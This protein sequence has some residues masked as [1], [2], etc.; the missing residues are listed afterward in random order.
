M[1]DD[2]GILTDAELDPVAGG[3]SNAL[4]DF[5]KDLTAMGTA[6]NFVHLCEDAVNTVVNVL[7][8]SPIPLL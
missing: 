3:K 4:N 7:V 2:L 1:N 6:A 5:Y 8:K